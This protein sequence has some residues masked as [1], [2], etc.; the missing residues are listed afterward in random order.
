MS[1]P[2]ATGKGLKN[3]ATGSTST[4]VFIR[5]RIILHGQKATLLSHRE[6]SEYPLEE[7]KRKP[8]LEGRAP[9]VVSHRLQC[10]LMLQARTEAP[11][12]ARMLSTLAS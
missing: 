7:A 10:A 5:F 4:E 12:N 8:V 3:Y 11:G 2:E 9:R 6:S 1:F